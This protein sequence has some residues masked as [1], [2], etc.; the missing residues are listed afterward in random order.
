MHVCVCVCVCTFVCVCVCMC[1]CVCD[2]VALFLSTLVVYKYPSASSLD[3]HDHLV[4][5]EGFAL[6]LVA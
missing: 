3:R 1:V 6:C 4:V 2:S 5:I